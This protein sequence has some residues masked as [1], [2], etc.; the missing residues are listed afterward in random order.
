[1]RSSPDRMIIL[2]PLIQ[3]NKLI[4]GF[5]FPTYRGRGVAAGTSFKVLPLYA[6]S[7]P[8]NYDVPAKTPE[9]KALITRG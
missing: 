7:Y 1:M 9:H 6:S 8:T 3:G 4:K 5:P 2:R